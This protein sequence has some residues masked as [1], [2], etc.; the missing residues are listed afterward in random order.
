MLVVVIHN[1][2]INETF[3]FGS[4]KKLLYHWLNLVHEKFIAHITLK[5]CWVPWVKPGIRISD[6]ACITINWA[7]IKCSCLKMIF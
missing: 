7:R 1:E 4:E 6:V 5:M 2:Y 3:K